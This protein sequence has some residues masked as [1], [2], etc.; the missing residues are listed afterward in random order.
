[1]RRNRHNADREFLLASL[2]AAVS[3]L[4]TWQLELELVGT[5]LRN[6]QMSLETACERLD[7]VG[8]L[9]HLPEPERVPS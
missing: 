1:M 2:R 9:L 8:L 3:N 6:D 7:D 5:A 4:R